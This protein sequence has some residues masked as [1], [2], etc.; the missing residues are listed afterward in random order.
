MVRP[1]PPKSPPMKVDSTTILLL[2]VPLRVAMNSRILNGDL[3]GL[4]TWIVPSSSIHTS[5]DFG[6]M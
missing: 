4:T 1:L 3:F 5:V 6:S 2:G